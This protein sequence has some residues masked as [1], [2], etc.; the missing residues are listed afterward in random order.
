MGW[1]HSKSARLT[2]CSEHWLSDRDLRHGIVDSLELAAA[3]TAEA[4]FAR[5][6]RRLQVGKPIMCTTEDDSV[7]VTGYEGLICDVCQ[8]SDGGHD[9]TVSRIGSLQ[10]RL[11]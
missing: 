4:D 2:R 5:L 10:Q 1:E 9:Q 11:S 3:C 7:S 6:V 8:P